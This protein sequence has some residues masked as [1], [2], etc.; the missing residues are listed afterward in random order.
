MRET[1]NSDTKDQI[2]RAVKNMD[3]KCDAMD[4]KITGIASLVS[5]AL[6]IINSKSDSI[7]K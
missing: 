3:E 5:D 4:K 6:K 7:E 1:V 2:N